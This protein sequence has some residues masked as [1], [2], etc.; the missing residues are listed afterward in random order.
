MIGKIISLSSVLVF[1]ACGAFLNPIYA[2][3]GAISAWITNTDPKSV[4][5]FEAHVSEEENLLSI[6]GANFDNGDWGNPEVTFNGD[7]LLVSGDVDPDLK[8]IQI[9]ADL[10]DADTYSGSFLV[11]VRTGLLLEN[12]DSYNLTLGNSE[13]TAPTGQVLIVAAKAQY[14]ESTDETEVNINGYWFSTGDWGPVVE[15]AG[16]TMIVNTPEPDDTHISA[17]APGDLAAAADGAPLVTVQTGEASQFYDIDSV[18]MPASSPDFS[19]HWKVCLED[20]KDT[21][22]K[23]Y[24]RPKCYQLVKD[25]TYNIKEHFDNPGPWPHHYFP[26]VPDPRIS[27]IFG[28]KYCSSLINYIGWM[29]DHVAKNMPGASVIDLDNEQHKMFFRLEPGG[30]LNVKK[31]Y[32]WD[33][34]TPP[35]KMAK[36]DDYEQILMRATVVHDTLYDLMREGELDDAC[37]FGGANG[38]EN[39]LVADNSFYRIALEDSG[40]RSKTGG[41][42]YGIRLGGFPN[43]CQDSVKWKRHAL[44]EAGLYEPIQCT[45]PEGGVVDLDG[46]ASKYAD[47][48]NWYWKE[49]GQERTRSGEK[50]SQLFSPGTYELGLLVDGFGANPDWTMYYRDTDTAKIVVLADT[51]PPVI[52]PHEDIT[53][54]NDPGQCSAVVSFDIIASDD[55]GEPQVSCNYGSGTSFPVGETTVQCSAIDIG[56][57]EVSMDFMVTVHDTEPPVIVGITRPIQIHVRNHKYQ[58]FTAEDFVYSVTDNCTALSLDDLV[59]TQVTSSEPED[60]RGDGHTADDFVIAPDGRSIELRMERQGKGNGRAYTVE[61][62]AADEYGNALTES[63][64]VRVTHDRKS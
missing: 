15:F 41:W 55:C 9:V 53:D 50:V 37:L 6:Q 54:V 29:A 31:G 63:F 59:F 60:V 10:P 2:Q 45:P 43:T 8:P 25:F 23:P 35:G 27:I 44:A 64:Q 21:D 58:T 20:W 5:I 62:R 3:E 38:F 16:T 52:E 24:T 12:F 28:P 40:S 48:W 1:L 34:P 22:H 36:P 46:S 57:N 33:G 61:I 51:E 26:C 13:P 18:V 14:D 17:W 49:N 56:K 39:Q 11:T 32:R 42:W 7:T 30:I 19:E 4:V 47:M